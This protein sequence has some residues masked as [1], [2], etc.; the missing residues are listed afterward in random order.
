MGATNFPGP[1]FVS[2]DLEQIE[3][4]PGGAILLPDP[5]PDRGPSMLFGGFGFPDTRLTFLKD[6]VQGY[7]GRV[8]ELLATTPIVSNNAIPAA[9]GTATISASGHTTSGT[10][11]T[12]VTAASFGITPTIPIIPF[13][14]TLN[15]A[16][17]VTAAIALDFGFCYGTTTTGSTANT[18][19]V[20]D[21]TLFFTGMPIVI[22]SAGAATGTTPLLT[23]V[24]G[25]PT[26]TTITINDAAQQA[27]SF[28]I[29][30]GNIWSPSEVGQLEPTAAMPVLA[31][32]PGLFLD[33]RQ[34]I[35]RGIVTTVSGGASSSNHLVVHGWD[36]YGQPMS[37]SIPQSA[38]TNYG[39]KAF[40]YIGSVVPD[41]TDGTNNYTVGTSDVF[42]F[43]QRT[44]LL[45]ETMVWWAGALSA[46]ANYGFTAA[47]TT[48]PAT[49][50]TGD[51]RGTIQPSAIGGGTGIG[52]TA[53]NGA[54]STITISGNR[55]RM[56]S[57]MTVW[58]QT[59]NR[60]S[61]PQYG[62][63]AVQA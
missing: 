45:E 61:Q 62:F 46:G 59:Q 63:G 52:S 47:D 55:L 44:D 43:A 8:G 21:S 5:N 13:S 54:V 58:Q 3:A 35:A 28:A 29:G 18:V 50:T 2:G 19:T 41:F 60:L 6:T 57:V 56:Q 11:L 31:S 9:H 7:T 12:L 1:I 23:W 15:G 34:A 33:P 42:G 4:S 39:K 16:A 38:A 24:T 48:N 22:G 40:K 25:R 30:T 17:P 14:T 49:S 37:E 20:L 51:V 27:G 10:P 26:A 36:I 53:S 32:G